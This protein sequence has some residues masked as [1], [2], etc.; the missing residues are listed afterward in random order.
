MALLYILM[1]KGED[2]L[3]TDVGHVDLKVDTNYLSDGWSGQCL[4]NKFE[5]NWVILATHYTKYI[6]IEGGER[7]LLTRGD[8][9]YLKSSSSAL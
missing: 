1:D 3:F 5:K 7:C 4:I 9:I 2:V 6:T 8:Y